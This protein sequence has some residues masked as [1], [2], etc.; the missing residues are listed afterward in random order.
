MAIELIDTF[1]AVV[2]SR[3]PILD[4]Q[5]FMNRFTSPNTDPNGPL[6]PALLASV[7]AFGAKFAD[8][9][10]FTADRDECAARDS[11][12]ADGSGRSRR[13]YSRSRCR[14][15]QLLAVRA[16]EVGEVNKA[17][18]IPSLA[19]VQALILLEGLFGREWKTHGL[20]LTD[21]VCNHKP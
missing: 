6:N 17:F 1:F 9:P 4:A 8:H 16:R 20:W 18:R 11:D 3:L 5:S 19:N 21:R 14:M 2:H 10:T 15:A 12:E 13:G 7:L